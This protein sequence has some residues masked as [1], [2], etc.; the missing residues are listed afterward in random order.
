MR[1]S[2]IPESGY[3]GVVQSSLGNRARV[4]GDETT[5]AEQRVDAEEQK[6][7]ADTPGAVGRGTGLQSVAVH[8]GADGVQ[9]ER[10]RTVSDEF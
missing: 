9:S 7:G 3:R 8:D 10:Y 1:P 2:Q 6:T 5:S 4:Q